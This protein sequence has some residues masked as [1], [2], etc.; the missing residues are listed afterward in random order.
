MDY[1]AN[2]DM[3]RS[4]LN[5]ECDLS[6]FDMDDRKSQHMKRILDEQAK[7]ARRWWPFSIF[8]NR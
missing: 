2:T 8:A 4:R 5:P 3:Y 6:G 7:R 1:E